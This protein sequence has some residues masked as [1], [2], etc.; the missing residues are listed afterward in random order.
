MED[1]FVTK[2]YLP[3]REAFDAYVDRIWRS[4]WLTNDGPL[5]E[6]LEERLCS[7]LNVDQLI[8]T[9]NGHAALELA[10]RDG[11]HV[12]G[13]VITTPFTF[14]ST[15]H[16]ITRL[17]AQPVFADIKQDNMTI[18]P[19]SIERCITDRTTA[20]VPVHV[21]GHA[22]DTEEI[23]KIA[24]KYKLKVIYDAAHAFGVKRNNRSILLEGD[25]S[26][27]SFHATKLFNTCE[28]GAVVFS[29]PEMKQALKASMNFGI[30]SE[31]LVECPGGNGKMN[32]LQA[33][34]GLATLPYVEEIISKRRTITE[35]YYSLLA[36]HPKI[37][38]FYPD[39]DPAVTYN[40][41][42]LPVLIS[43]SNSLSRD[44]VY[45]SLKL[46]HIYTRRY[47]WPLASDYRC[48]QNCAKDDLSVAKSV[49]QRVLCLP[50]YADLDITTVD[51][52]CESLL[53]LL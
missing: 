48:Y 6:E 46:K 49:S 10:L 19:R 17:G 5:K 11:A 9:V 26:I 43:S 23:S 3:P 27:L 25:F 12:S 22:C 37:Q 7:Y 47:F 42:Y 31:E 13:E 18:D 4:H 2:P 52:V 51:Y 36:G 38:F 32:E 44:E 34:V 28:G 15:I 1:I 24:E 50:I 39:Y 30:I 14:A 41:A 35:R 20:I 29:N 16:A 40:F 8:L 21:Y 45:D 53:A 33:A